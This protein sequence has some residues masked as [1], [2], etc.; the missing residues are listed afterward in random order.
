MVDNYD[1]D[2]V[3]DV[4]YASYEVFKN[5]HWHNIAASVK[6]GEKVKMPK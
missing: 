2:D 6:N 4:A 3:G 1:D 5:H